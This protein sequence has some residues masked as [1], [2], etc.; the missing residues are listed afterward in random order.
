MI[1][2]L[3]DNPILHKVIRNTLLPRHLIHSH[4]VLVVSS[5]HFSYQYNFL[6]LK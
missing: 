3:I 2:K 4:Q 5:F 6:P 1:I